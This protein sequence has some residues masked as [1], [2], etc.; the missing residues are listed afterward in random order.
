MDGDD[1]FVLLVERF[2][3]NYAGAWRAGY[4]MGWAN[5]GFS[6]QTEFLLGDFVVD[7]R[8]LSGL[9]G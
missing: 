5:S 9:G 3:L 4:L 6:E 1:D 7:V 2:D 8:P